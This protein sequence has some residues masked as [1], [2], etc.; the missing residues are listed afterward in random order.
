M[1]R[2]RRLLAISTTLEAMIASTRE[3]GLL[4]IRMFKGFGMKSG[5]GNVSNRARLVQGRQVV[6]CIQGVVAFAVAPRLWTG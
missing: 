6:W 4:A 5:C 1:V 3:N 2:A